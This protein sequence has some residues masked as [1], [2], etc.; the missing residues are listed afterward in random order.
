MKNNLLKSIW[1][2][3][4]CV[5]AT[6]VYAQVSPKKFKK[7]KGIE[8]TYQSVYKGKVRPGEMLESDAAYQF[9]FGGRDRHGLSQGLDEF[10]DGNQILIGD[11]H[12][13]DL[14]TLVET[15]DIGR[16]VQTHLVACLPQDGG[17]HG[18]G[19]AFAIGTGDM[20][21]LQLLFGV[22]HFGQQFLGAVQA[23]GAAF[24]KNTVD[25]GNGFIYIHVVISP[26]NGSILP[27]A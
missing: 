6:S 23:R 21:K 13:V 8:V 14:H 1:L 27:D 18:S 3:A 7:A 25:I 17:G 19:G 24:P 22:A 26:F 15:I 20:D 9:E 5:I 4:L 2:V 11:L 16:C 10:G 12:T